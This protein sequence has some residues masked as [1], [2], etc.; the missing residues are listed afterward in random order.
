MGNA[1]QGGIHENL[2]AGQYEVRTDS[3]YQSV[4][5]SP[6]DLNKLE[7]DVEG[8]ES[9]SVINRNDGLFFT[10]K[11]LDFIEEPKLVIV[12][13]N[14][15]F[16]VGLVDMTKSDA[17]YFGFQ[18]KADLLD[19][20]RESYLWHRRYNYRPRRLWVRLIDKD[21]DRKI[22]LFAPV[23]EEGDQQIARFD[24]PKN[25]RGLPIIDVSNADL[26]VQLYF[27]PYDMND[28]ITP[29]LT[30]ESNRKILKPVDKSTSGQVGKLSYVIDP[31]QGRVEVNCEECQSG[32]FVGCEINGQL[33][34]CKSREIRL[35]QDKRVLEIWEF[36]IDEES[37][38]KFFL[39]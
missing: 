39:F 15:P 8:G 36:D 12:N 20:D 28:S 22:D 24:I 3:K 32:I 10:S 30:P 31:K 26:D 23:W 4:S 16:E 17:L 35:K 11:P 33:A 21:T 13:E 19:I 25:D 7:F 2:K 5:D 9:I 34:R 37:N 14:W 6:G 29:E 27:Q 1:K 38:P 18:P